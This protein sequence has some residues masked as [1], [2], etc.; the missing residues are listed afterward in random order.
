MIFLLANW[1]AL[2]L[3]GLLA[4][5]ALFFGL[6]RHEVSA[7]D[8]FRVKVQAEGLA[9]KAEATRVNDQHQKTLEDVSHAWSN[10]LKPARD[11]AVAAYLAHQPVVMRTSPGLGGL[12]INAN[13]SGSPDAAGQERVAP[14]ASQVAACQPDAGFIADA[15]EDAL[16]VKSWQDFAIENGLPVK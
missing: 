11:G 8:S 16:K 7:F 9:A 3:A 1:K 12:S 4:V 13:G 5:V 15:A 10:Q 14:D 6:W 2:A